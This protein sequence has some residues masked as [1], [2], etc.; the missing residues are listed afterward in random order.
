MAKRADKGAWVAA[1]HPCLRREREYMGMTATAS[2]SQEECVWAH[3]YHH[4]PSSADEGVRLGTTAL[5]SL[6]H[7][8][9]WFLCEKE[10]VMAA[11]AIPAL[12][13]SAAAR[14]EWWSPLAKGKRF[15]SCQYMPLPLLR[16]AKGCGGR[17]RISH[18]S[19]GEGRWM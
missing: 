1:P 13:S 7:S 12:A 15:W 3:P 19:S 8:P 14:Y 17:G 2:L 5:L 6:F 16:E 10:C 9:P 4:S 11:M 18:S